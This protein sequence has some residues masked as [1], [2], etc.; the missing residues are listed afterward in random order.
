MAG[1]APK[2]IVM[3]TTQSMKRLPVSVVG[4]SCEE[5]GVREKGG[6]VNTRERWV[7]NMR[8]GC[9][10]DERRMCGEDEDE[11]RMCGEDE[12]RMCG[13]DKK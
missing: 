2:S 5:K 8:E 12:S 10:E 4:V 11:R 6:W 13:E 3:S 1:D 9:G 7:V